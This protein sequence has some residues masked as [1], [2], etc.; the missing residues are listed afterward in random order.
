MRVH[1]RLW[2]RPITFEEELWFESWMFGEARAEG[3]K[4][5]LRKGEAGRREGDLF[6]SV[7]GFA[8]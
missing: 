5:L 1:L 2:R 4:L 8:L 7:C 6:R 3:W